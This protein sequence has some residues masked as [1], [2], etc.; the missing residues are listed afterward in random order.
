[1]MSKNSVYF[2]VGVSNV[3]KQSIIRHRQ[4]TAYFQLTVTRI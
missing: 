1:M 4:Q 3:N 2:T